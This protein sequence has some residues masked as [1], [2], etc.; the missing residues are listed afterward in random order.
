[1]PDSSL[2]SQFQ[3]HFLRKGFPDHLCPSP[4]L[5]CFSCHAL[6]YFFASVIIGLIS[7]Y[8]ELSFPIPTAMPISHGIPALTPMSGSKKNKYLSSITYCRSAPS[9]PF[10]EHC[11]RP[12][13]CN[14]GFLKKPQISLPARGSP[15]S[16]PPCSQQ[17]E[18]L[19]SSIILIMSLPFLEAYNSS[20]CLLN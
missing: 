5:R 16:N 17:Q 19:S 8:Y 14:P 1:M 18:P 6:S 7:P 15:S 2:S 13:P 10:P 11:S 9:I 3:Y 20:N 4:Q 12:C